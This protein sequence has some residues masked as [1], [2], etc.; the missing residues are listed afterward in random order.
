M[1]GD[2]GEAEV[3]SVL[4]ARIRAVRALHYAAD[5][6]SRLTPQCGECHGKAGVHP[7]GCWAAVDRVP[8][9]GECSRGLRAGIAY[10]CRTL[11]ALDGEEV[12][13]C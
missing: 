10:P 13:K 1:S 6:D 8:V 4:E 5:D 11:R 9:C 7:C 2:T 3:R 12:G